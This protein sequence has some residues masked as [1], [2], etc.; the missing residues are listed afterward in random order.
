MNSSWSCCKLKLKYFFECIHASSGA[1]GPRGHTGATG[2][3]GPQGYTGVTG[4]FDHHY[5]FCSKVKVL[6]YWSEC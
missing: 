6:E 1:T 2:A 4:K 5:L 3:R